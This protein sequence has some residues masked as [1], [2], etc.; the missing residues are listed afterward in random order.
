MSQAVASSAYGP[1]FMSAV[2]QGLPEA[3]RIVDDRLAYRLLPVSMRLMVRASRWKPLGR[4]LMNAVEKST[5]GIRGSVLCRKRYIEDQLLD[6]MAAGLD[7][8]V[9]LGAGLDTLAYRLPPLV[10]LPV[11]EV[12]LPENI[13]AKR[14][15]LE[16]LY[17][18][19]PA[20]VRLVPLDFEAQ[21]LE[22]DLQAAGYSAGERSFFVWE[23]VTQYLT[24]TAVRETMQFL[25]RAGVGSRL[26]FTYIL[27]S[28]I[29]GTNTDGLESLYRRMRVNHAY[30]LFG[31]RSPD[32]SAFVGEYGWTVRE[33]MHAADYRRRYVMPTGRL[34]AVA[35]IE[36]AVCAE[37]T[38]F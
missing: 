24:E 37:K 33:Q 35:E 3:E 22:T 38:A 25:A 9:L 7:S 10:R 30:W 27:K 11:Y 5:P 23:G 26:V 19:V 15:A 13:A 6:A 4:A 20:H 18:T 16:K 12:D 34:L 31:L 29:E 2:E 32:V 14:K 28:F 21:T 36:P 17:G 1:M 8:V